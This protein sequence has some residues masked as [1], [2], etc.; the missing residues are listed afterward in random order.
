ML[1]L[2]P[3]YTKTR[4]FVSARMYQAAVSTHMSVYVSMHCMSMH[5]VSVRLSLHR[6]CL[7]QAAVCPSYLSVAVQGARASCVCI[8]T[9]AGA[10]ARQVES[11]QN[12]RQACPRVCACCYGFG[13]RSMLAFTA[14]AAPYWLQ[15]VK[16]RPLVGRWGCHLI[17]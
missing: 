14:H 9:E 12:P 2:S 16:P 1:H 6:V 7:Y 13:F 8:E 17:R 15:R 4:S 11:Y 10:L 5:C 3:A